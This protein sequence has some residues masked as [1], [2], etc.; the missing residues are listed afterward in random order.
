MFSISMG[1]RGLFIERE[2][3]FL[4]VGGSESCG[5]GHGRPFS[6][7]GDGADMEGNIT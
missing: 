5:R 7:V 6:V 1:C 2:T 4:R 3:E